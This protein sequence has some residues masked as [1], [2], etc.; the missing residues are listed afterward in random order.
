M[1]EPA[2]AVGVAVGET[3]PRSPGRG[4]RIRPPGACVDEDV[5]RWNP[6]PA[7]A[8]SKRSRRPSPTSLSIGP[9]RSRPPS[10]PMSRRHSRRPARSPGRASP[11]SD[12]Q[13]YPRRGSRGRA[14]RARIPFRRI[15]ETRYDPTGT[16]CRAGRPPG[17]SA[18]SS[19]CGSRHDRPDRQLRLVHLQPGP[20][21]R[22]DRPEPRP[23]RG[24]QRPDHASTRSRRGGR[25][26]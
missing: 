15:A 21:P 17:R 25:R 9:D 11:C 18:P 5:R 23:A 19:S 2:V 6:P 1:V 8:P 22:R 4:V 12:G 13:V 7:P 10:G 3:P 16:S 26:T 20:A 24:P 14:F